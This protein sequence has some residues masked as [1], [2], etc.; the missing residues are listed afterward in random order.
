MLVHKRLHCDEGV[1][2]VPTPPP[3]VLPVICLANQA[4]VRWV[5][6]YPSG[7]TRVQGFFTTEDTEITENP[8]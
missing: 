5:Q 1:H 3:L 7:G 2:I 6:V 4:S 8:F